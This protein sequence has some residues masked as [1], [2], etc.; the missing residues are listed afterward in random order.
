LVIGLRSL[1]W[2]A[3][4]L[5]AVALSVGPADASAQCQRRYHNLVQPVYDRLVIVFER[6]HLTCSQAARVGNA[7]GNAYQR[8]LPL[9]DYPPPPNGV[10][11]GEGHAFQVRT[12]YGAFTCRMTAR[13]SD[14]VTARCHRGVRFVRFTSLNSYFVHGQ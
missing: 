13:G 4:L 3:P 1:A 8:G 7:V 6:R 9:A 11:G 14:F 5:S 12:R 2:A 10:P